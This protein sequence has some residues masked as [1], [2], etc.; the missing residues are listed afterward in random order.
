MAAVGRTPSIL[1]ST[2]VT[3]FAAVW[4]LL[5][6]VLGHMGRPWPCAAVGA[7]LLLAA[8]MILSKPAQARG[9]GVLIISLSLVT[10]FLGGRAFIPAFIGILGGLAAVAAAPESPKRIGQ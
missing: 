2:S 10:F 7:I 3:A 5:A 4:L 8:V 6:P 1:I 9:W